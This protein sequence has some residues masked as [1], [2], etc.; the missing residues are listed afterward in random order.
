[1]TFS[2]LLKLNGSYGLANI[3]QARV[4]EREVSLG[5]GAF[6]PTLAPSGRVLAEERNQTW[7]IHT[8][9]MTTCGLRWRHGEWDD[10]K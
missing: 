9:H 5:A 2:S 3:F 6:I 10:I 7:G 8:H 4:L 1:M